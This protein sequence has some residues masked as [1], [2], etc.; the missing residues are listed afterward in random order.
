MGVRAPATTT[1][2][3]GNMIFPFLLQLGDFREDDGVSAAFPRF[4][5]AELRAVDDV[6]HDVFAVVFLARG[7][8][9]DPRAQRDL[10]ETPR[11]AHPKSGPLKFT[12]KIL[13]PEKIGVR[14]K[15]PQPPRCIFY[16][17]IVL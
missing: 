17:H 3:V 16:R 4:F 7:S 2:S 15:K 8:S 13:R 12:P 11:R 6:G 14:K 5:D 10:C 1:I 9:H